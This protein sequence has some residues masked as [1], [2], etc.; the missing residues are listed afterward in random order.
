MTNSKTQLAGLGL[1][2]TMILA[3]PGM[4]SAGVVSP[5]LGAR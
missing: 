4:A 3:A 2:A 5:N 1:A